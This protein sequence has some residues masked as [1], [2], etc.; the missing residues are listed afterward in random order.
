MSNDSLLTGKILKL[1]GWPDG[2]IIGIAKDIGAGLADQGIDRE[3]ILSRL[4][5]VRQNPGP[6]LADPMAD[7][8]VSASPGLGRIMHR[9]TNLRDQ[10]LGYPIWGRENMTMAPSHKW[11]MP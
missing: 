8:R 6:F 3:T 7:L 9:M 2:R 5:E 4:N 1:H 11:T 10:P